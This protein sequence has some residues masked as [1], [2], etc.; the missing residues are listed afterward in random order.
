MFKRVHAFV[1]MLVI[2]LAGCSNPPQQ[3]AVL[4]N[5]AKQQL[6]KKRVQTLSN[7][8]SWKLLGRASV[9]YRDENY[10]FGLDW[11]QQNANSHQLL[12]RHPVTQSQLAKL[13]SN[14]SKVTLTT[15]KGAVL[16]DSSADRLIEQQ[17]RVKIPVDGM[18]SWVRGLAAP[19]YPVT[20]IVLDNFGRP[21]TIE[22]AGWS[23]RYAAY[24]GAS[25][26]A[27]PSSIV[28]SRSQPQNVRVKVRVKSW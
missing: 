10:P 22:Q 24:K 20:H 16:R 27:M 15:N 5:A 26:A 9:T 23:V 17:L 8:Q 6:W 1:F 25:T 13:V 14:N 4:D 7:Q 3:G 18:Q 28:I 11:Q 19:Q 21:T 12:I 2:G